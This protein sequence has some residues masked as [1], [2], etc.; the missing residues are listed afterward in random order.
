MKS[1]A[2]IRKEVSDRIKALT[3]GKRAAAERRLGIS[4]AVFLRRSFRPGDL[5]MG[6]CPLPDEPDITPVL[7]LLLESGYRLCLPV[8]TPHNGMVAREVTDLK[9]DLLTNH[10][11]IREPS[12]FCPEAVP[13]DIRLVIV[14]GRA[15]T[16]G[17]ARLGRGKGFYDRFLPRTPARRVALAYQCQ[18]YAEDELPVEEHDARLHEIF[19]A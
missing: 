1:K 7:E 10:W 5:V 14:P 19:R 18:I 9:T 4:F 13:L 12:A 11:H 17:G 16:P 8:I 3:P 2:E 6:Y 15:F